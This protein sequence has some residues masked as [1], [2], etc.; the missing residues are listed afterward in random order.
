M[1]WQAMTLSQFETLKGG[2]AAAAAVELFVT[3][4]S[5]A[6]K[7]TSGSTGSHVN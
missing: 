6:K 3:S 7:A 4:S 1:L 2:R 5:H